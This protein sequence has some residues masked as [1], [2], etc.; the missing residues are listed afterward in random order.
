VG[1]GGEVDWLRGF[2]ASK[3]TDCSGNS[4]MGL[5][6][7]HFTSAIRKR[8]PL[9]MEMGGGRRQKQKQP[10]RE[11]EEARRQGRAGQDRKARKELRELGWPLLAA[12]RLFMIGNRQSC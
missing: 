6:R 5:G 10:E 9:M 11:R 12:W 7:C 8:S 2:E 3:G 1:C 4:A